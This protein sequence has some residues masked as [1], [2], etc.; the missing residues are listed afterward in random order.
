[1]FT[2]RTRAGGDWAAAEK[3]NTDIA[4]N[5]M[6]RKH[7]QYI[8]FSAVTLPSHPGDAHCCTLASMDELKIETLPGRRQ[9]V[10]IIRLDGPFVL[11]GVFEFQSIARAGHDA[12]TIIDLTEVPFMDSAALG[13]VMGL[14]VSCQRQKR[15]YG[16]VG[17]SERLRTL[18]QVAGVAS[19][20]V[21]FGTVQEAEEKLA[22]S[23]AAQ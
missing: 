19:L 10:R 9:G 4:K 2:A 15:K 3:A 18:F 20:L 1:M 11:Q 12:V 16:L 17:A 7:L 22:A 5:E 13:A 21:N 6:V 14:H 23:A 8:A